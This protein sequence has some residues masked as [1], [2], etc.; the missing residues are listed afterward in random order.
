MDQEP[1]KLIRELQ[2]EKC[3]PAVLDRVTQRIAREKAP[4]R[5]VGNLLGWAVSIV[6]LLGVVAVWQWQGHRE[7]KRVAAAEQLRANRALVVEQT[8]EA[9]GYIGQAFIRVAAHTE[10]ALSKEAVPPLR[11]GFEVVKNTM[12]KP[13]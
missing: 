10:N 5:S 6:V 8:R 3:P 7:A 11:N 2:H 12:N 9:F 4:T 13:V 1:Q